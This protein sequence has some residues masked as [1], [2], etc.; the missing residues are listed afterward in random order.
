[1]K[2]ALVHYWLVNMR[3]GENVLEMFCDIFP[4]A[5][6]YTLVY[7]PSAISEKINRH[8]VTP[9]FIQK[10]PWGV[11]KYQQY[12]P[13]HPFAVEQFD[14]NEYDLVISSESGAAKG[15]ILKPETCHICYCETPM[16]YLWNMY[17]EEKRPLGKFKKILWAAVSNYMRQWDYIN[18][19]RVDYFIANSVNVQRRIQRYYNRDAEVIHCPVN[20][21]RFR[22]EPEEEYY[23]FVGQLTPYKKA[24]LAVRA[25][26]ESGKK[27]VVI[28]DGP[29]KRQLQEIAKQNVKLLGA[30]NGQELVD[31]YAKCKGFIFPGE[32]DFGITP[33]EAMASGKPVI[34]FAKGG[35]LETVLDGKTGVYFFEQTEQSLNKAVEKAESLAWDVNYIRNHAKKFDV[36]T[37]TEKLKKFIFE[38]YNEFQNNLQQPQPAKKMVASSNGKKAKVHKVET[39]SSAA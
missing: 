2:V 25:F 38:K 37:T 31:Y 24:D 5:D 32:E 1:M 9:S 30:K 15:V 36:E 39:L 35:A 20:F 29:Q 19:Q 18:A 13:L 4:D 27:L 34:A 8:K 14:L 16:R 6:I 22:Y 12:L 7:D 21:S 26:N 10:L 33:L 3:G 11:K 23:L 28:G 17:H